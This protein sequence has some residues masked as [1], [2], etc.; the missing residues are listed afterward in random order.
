MPIGPGAPPPLGPWRS[1]EARE[2][3]RRWDDRRG[4]NKVAGCEAGVDSRLELR[5]FM[6]LMAALLGAALDA[7]QAPTGKL[8]RTLSPVLQSL[9]GSGG[10]HGDAGF[11]GAG[12]PYRGGVAA[13]GAPLGVAELLVHPPFTEVASS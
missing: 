12:P 5:R 11:L 8:A 4:A 7:E 6:R 13:H 2:V 3:R 10:L 9:E 1:T